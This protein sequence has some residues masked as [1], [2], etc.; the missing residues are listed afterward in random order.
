M[1][2]VPCSGVFHFATLYS[3][4]QVYLACVLWSAFNQPHISPFKHFLKGTDYLFLL[5]LAGGECQQI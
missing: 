3:C 5:M 2:K 1:L 4:S